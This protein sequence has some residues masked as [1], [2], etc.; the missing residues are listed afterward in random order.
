VLLASQN[1]TVISK[2]QKI[3]LRE[4]IQSCHRTGTS[5]D[6]CKTTKGQRF[7]S[8]SFVKELVK[9]DVE[10]VTGRKKAR[11]KGAVKGV[12][13]KVGFC[14]EKTRERPVGE[15]C[16]GQDSTVGNSADKR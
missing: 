4:R 3:V 16:M 1:S 5:E 10:R 8:S 7:H 6:R 2:P 13:K 14:N 9:N 11:K 12:G 15:E